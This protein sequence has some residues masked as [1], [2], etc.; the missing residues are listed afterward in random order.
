M[1]HNMTLPQRSDLGI[2]IGVRLLQVGNVFKD[3]LKGSSEWKTVSDIANPH[4]KLHFEF[5]LFR[6]LAFAIV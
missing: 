2:H 4:L 3:V 1:K 6:R 5:L